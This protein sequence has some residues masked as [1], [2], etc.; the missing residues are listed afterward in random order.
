MSTSL[1]AVFIPIL[2][3]GGIV[4]RLFREFAV[5][6]SAAIGVSLLISLSTTPMMCAQILRPPKE[7]KHNWLYRS[8]QWVFDLLLKIYRAMLTWVMRHQ[9]LTLGVTILTAAL[10]I[11]LYTKIPTGFFPQQ[12]TGRVMGSVQADQ[13]IS[14]AA[15]KQKM[16][17]FVSIVMKDS[18]VQ[19]IVGFAGG[20]TAKNQGRM[21]IVLKPLDQRKISADKVIARLRPKLSHIVGATAFLQSVQDL[22]IGGRMGNAQYQ[23]TLSGEDLGELYTWAPRLMEKHPP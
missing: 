12:D 7:E 14:F 18:N 16:E 11:F 13:D 10:T 22:Q 9:P 23:Y 5:T 6:L 21:F 4:G 8:F 2:L 20:N 19:T 3:M 15:M 1:V 17:Q